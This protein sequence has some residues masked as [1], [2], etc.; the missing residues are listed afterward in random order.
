MAGAVVPPTP[1]AAEVGTTTTPTENETVDA[2]FLL[3]GG[4]GSGSMGMGENSVLTDAIKQKKESKQKTS[5]N[6]SSGGSSSSSGSSGSANI[7]KRPRAEYEREHNDEEV[8]PAPEWIDST[9]GVVGSGIGGSCGGGGGGFMIGPTEKY[10]EEKKNDDEGGRDYSYYQ[11]KRHQWSSSEAVDDGSYPE[12]ED[13]VQAVGQLFDDGCND[14]DDPVDVIDKPDAN[15][16]SVPVVQVQPMRQAEK[17]PLY[18]N[19][20][21]DVNVNATV[22]CHTCTSI[23]RHPGEERHNLPTIKISSSLYTSNSTNVIAPFGNIGITMDERPSNS[24]I[25]GID[26]TP[27]RRGW[28]ENNVNVEMD[29]QLPPTVSRNLES[30]FVSAGKKIPVGPGPGPRPPPT[31]RPFDQQARQIKWGGGKTL[32]GRSKKRGKKSYYKHL[33]ENGA[34]K[35]TQNLRIPELM[36]GQPIDV[37][38]VLTCLMENRS[39]CPAPSFTTK[40][41]TFMD[42]FTCKDLAKAASISRDFRFWVSRETTRKILAFKESMSAA[43]PVKFGVS[44]DKLADKTTEYGF[45]TALQQIGDPRWKTEDTPTNMDFIEKIVGWCGGWLQFLHSRHDGAKPQPMRREEKITTLGS[46]GSGLPQSALVFDLHCNGEWRWSGLRPLSQSTIDQSSST[47]SG[48]ITDVTTIYPYSTVAMGDLTDAGY[49]KRKK[50]SRPSNYLLSTSAR[51][52][53]RW[54]LSVSITSEKSAETLIHEFDFT[55]AVLLHDLDRTC[56]LRPCCSN[57][58]DPDDN[59]RVDDPEYDYEFTKCFHRDFSPSICCP[60][61]TEPLLGWDHRHKRHKHLSHV[62]FSMCYWKDERFER[63]EDRPMFHMMSELVCQKE[64]F[65]EMILNA[66]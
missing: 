59:W 3:Q 62:H 27:N 31:S 46:H 6:N 22:E 37:S 17:R 63:V 57:Y 58:D 10:G 55:P 42:Y 18:D 9:I 12:G 38:H 21:V 56:S 35:I 60:L 48:L 40:K 52:E 36:E 14:D 1:P 44:A 23:A 65:R 8:G 33:R 7:T 5:R 51:D 66:H 50:T 61:P 64:L 53:R 19:V 24:D 2:L 39:V 47:S 49:Y 26:A 16:P 20:N 25:N 30:M 34:A 11:P 54:S 45:H 4:L 15:E 13:P 28:D 43:W 32:R 41:V 29:Q